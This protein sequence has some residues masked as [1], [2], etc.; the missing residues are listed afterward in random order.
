MSEG[1]PPPPHPPPHQPRGLVENLINFTKNLSLQNV[2]VIGLLGLIAIPIYSLWSLFNDDEL[3]Q[4]FLSYTKE[5][6]IPGVPC[7]VIVTSQAGGGEAY[8][9]LTPYKIDAPYEY[10]VL[11]RARSSMSDSAIQEIC[12]NLLKHADL[13]EAALLNPADKP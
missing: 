11:S 6:F 12:R 9:V 8:N 7:A 4:E 13:I 5:R 3:R 2:L 1:L 10:H